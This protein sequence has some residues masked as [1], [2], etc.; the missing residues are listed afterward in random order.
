MQAPNITLCLINT[1]FIISKKILCCCCH[2]LNHNW[3]LFLRCTEFSS[4]EI[5]IKSKGAVRLHPP[6]SNS[7]LANMG[8]R[9][10]S[11]I[12]MP[13]GSVRRQSLSRP[14]RRTESEGRDHCAGR[15]TAMKDDSPP[16]TQPDTAPL[17][18]KRRVTLSSRPSFKSCCF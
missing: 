12:L 13:S 2:F 3:S 17:H 10:N 16:L 4:L 5:K 1:R 7:I 14:V 11:A 9:G 8:F 15:G 18:Q 6:D